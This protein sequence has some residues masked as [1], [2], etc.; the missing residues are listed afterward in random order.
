MNIR[1]IHERHGPAAER[2]RRLPIRGQQVPAM[3]VVTREFGQLGAA[4]RCTEL[5]ET[6]VVPGVHDIMRARMPL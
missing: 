6:V 2:L 3:L 4:E 1:R 5:V